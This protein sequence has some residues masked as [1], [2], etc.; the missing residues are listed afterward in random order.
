MAFFANRNSSLHMPMPRTLQA[1]VVIEVMPGSATIP[2][3]LTA[4]TLTA[5][6]LGLVV[7]IL[8]NVTLVNDDL[9]EDDETFGISAYSTSGLSSNPASVIISNDDSPPALV[10]PLLVE[11]FEGDTPGGG[12]ATVSVPVK[13]SNISVG[14]CCLCQ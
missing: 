10:A 3:D 7:P 12:G 9:Y 8:Y 6:P 4:A 1:S 11:V 5:P 2:E 13:L 14:T